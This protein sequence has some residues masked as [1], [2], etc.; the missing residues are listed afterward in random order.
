[1][2]KV[3]QHQIFSQ[4]CPEVRSTEIEYT[5]SSAQLWGVVF[6]EGEKYDKTLAESWKGDMDGILFFV[7]P[8]VTSALRHRS[9]RL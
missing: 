8:F 4:P 7:R 6:K 5:D 9:E 1:M 3:P 2:L